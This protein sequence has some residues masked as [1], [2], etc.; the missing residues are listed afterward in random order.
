MTFFVNNFDK[1]R[2]NNSV[3]IINTRRNDNLHLPITHLSSYQRGVYYSGVKLF[4][5]LPWN[6]LALKHD[7]I[8]LGRSYEVICKVTLFILLTN[9]LNIQKFKCKEWI[10]ITCCWDFICYKHGNM[11]NNCYLEPILNSD[12]CQNETTM[13]ISQYAI[14]YIVGQYIQNKQMLHLRNIELL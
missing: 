9:L 3:Y 11:Y 2:T 8:N 12:I 4:N 13:K 14:E 6:I 1:F 10:Y 7:K 5:I